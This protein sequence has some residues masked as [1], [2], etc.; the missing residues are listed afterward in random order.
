MLVTASV[1]VLLTA[2]SPSADAAALESLLRISLATYR[3]YCRECFLLLEECCRCRRESNQ[4]PSQVAVL[5]ECRE[6]YFLGLQVAF[7][8]CRVGRS[9]WRCRA[10]EGGVHVLCWSWVQV[11]CR[12]GLYNR[13]GLCVGAC[14]LSSLVRESVIVLL[15]CGSRAIV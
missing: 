15:S 7:L 10:C 3:C 1:L 12:C 14:C 8:L 4:L 13:R 11:P 9:W 2:P 5:V 6:W